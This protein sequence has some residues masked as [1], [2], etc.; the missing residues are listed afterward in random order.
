M[1]R[2]IL[3]LV[4]KLWG[5]Q[6]N[7]NKGF[8]QVEYNRSNQKKSKIFLLGGVRQRHGARNHIHVPL[9]P[10][11]FHQQPGLHQVADTFVLHL[12]SSSEEFTLGGII[13]HT[14]SKCDG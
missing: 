11:E 13:G 1:V 12:K 3:R 2:N 6:L 5:L 9:L 7:N 4:S 14:T 10:Q 8:E